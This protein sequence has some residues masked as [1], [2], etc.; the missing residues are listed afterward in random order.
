MTVEAPKGKTSLR[1]ETWSDTTRVLL[2]SGLA[3]GLPFSFDHVTNADRSLK[4]E[5]FSL[6]E[7]NLVMPDVLSVQP[8]MPSIFS[9]NGVIPVRRGQCYARVTLLFRGKQVAILSSAYV[10]DAK[11]ITYPPGVHEGFAEGPGYL[12][13]VIVS[14]PAAG[15][16]SICTV[17]ENVRWRVRSMIFSLTTSA[18]VA[19]RGVYV[20]FWSKAMEAPVCIVSDVVAQVADTVVEYRG[21]L[22]GESRVGVASPLG[23]SLKLPDMV[24]RGE[25]VIEA[26][27]SLLDANDQFGT[28][29]LWV[30]EW[31]EE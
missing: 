21:G 6:S 15:S 29:V 18:V 25:M 5:D 11:G 19:D 26:K 4:V 17:P 31:I 13:M 10:T 2:F 30:E 27:A 1:L 8:K 3:G 28:W 24:L 20:E 7:H 9:F 16:Q 12:Y 23:V 14:S 22:G